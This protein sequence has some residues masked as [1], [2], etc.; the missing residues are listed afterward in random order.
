MSKSLEYCSAASDKSRSS[1][2]DRDWTKAIESESEPIFDLLLEGRRELTVDLGRAYT[3]GD[4]S[5]IRVDIVFDPS[6]DFQYFT[7][8]SCRHDGTLLFIDDLFIK[9]A[10]KV[11]CLQTWYSKLDAPKNGDHI[12][13]VVGNFVMLNEYGQELAPKDKPWM[14]QRTTVLLPLKMEY[15]K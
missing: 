12:K 2:A 11:C 15:I 14:Q 13:F 3:N 5:L 9:C 7:S 4:R 8:E 10:L 6:A 1:Y